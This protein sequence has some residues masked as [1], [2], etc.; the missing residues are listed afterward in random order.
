MTHKCSDAATRLYKTFVQG[1]CIITNARTA[2]MCKLTENSFRDVNIA[3]ANELSIICDKLEI[4]VW[5]LIKLANRHPR[6][7]ILQPGPGVGGHCIAV[8]PWFIVSQ[9]PDQ[10]RLIR[11]AREVNDAKPGWV[12]EKVKAAI[13]DLRSH[14]SGRAVENVTVSFLG[15]SFKANIDDT[16]ESPAIDIVRT[17][18]REHPG[19]VLVAEPHLQSLPHSLLG[20]RVTLVPTSEA[21]ERADVIVMLVDHQSFSQVDFSSIH[22]RTLVDTRGVWQT[23]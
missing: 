4:D 21:V 20:E 19:T 14:G 7:N 3:F 6:V 5:K 23:S 15:L 1:E 17:L 18:A 13:N 10:A 8:D 2:E 12:V 22:T 16:R 9:S 11:C